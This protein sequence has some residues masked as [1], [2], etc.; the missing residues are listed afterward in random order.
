MRIC[1]RR[2][3]LPVP[4]S[5]HGVVS[6]LRWCVSTVRSTSAR[7][8]EWAPGRITTHD[9]RDRMS[10]F[11]FRL[12]GVGATRCA[13]TLARDGWIRRQYRGGATRGARAHSAGAGAKWIEI[14]N[15]YR[16]RATERDAIASACRQF[17][18]ALYRFARGGSD[19]LALSAFAGAMG[20]VRRDPTLG[21]EPPRHSAGAG[22]PTHAQLG[23]DSI[24]LARAQ[25]AYRR[26]LQRSERAVRG[27]VMHC[28]SPAPSGGESTLL[29]PDLVYAAMH[30]RSPALIE[31][32]LPPGCDDHSGI[33]SQWQ[34]WF[35]RSATGPV[36]R[37]LG[38]SSRRCTCATRCAPRS[39]R[40]RSTRDTTRAV[41]A[42]E[43]T[44]DSLAPHHV[45]VRS[46]RA[47]GSSATTCSTGVR[48]SS[49]TR[50]RTAWY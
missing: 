20:L 25:L 4:R 24:H 35:A 32:P 37:F 22:G 43:E 23:D 41:A 9:G 2:Y 13:R 31:G 8:R 26:L 29:D 38:G 34:G 19:P 5:T 48:R 21:A 12:N 15:P 45:H 36:F 44:I 46:R 30:E 3:L 50:A 33:S 28:S 6:A 49:R 16:L 11:R 7:L 40:W 10:I 42:L 1:Q 27:V 18:L 39:I 14:R 47:K 17:N